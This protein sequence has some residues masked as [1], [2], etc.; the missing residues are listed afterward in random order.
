MI[1]DNTNSNN[2]SEL[3]ENAL[4]DGIALL[5]N[6]PLN[7][8]SFDVVA[9]IRNTLKIKK[10]GHAGTL[11]PLASGL[12]IICCGKYTKKIDEFQ[13]LFKEYTGEIKLGAVTKSYDSEFEEENICDVGHIDDS[14]VKQV[15]SQFVGRQ[16]QYPPMFSAK[17]VKGKKLYELAR[18]DIQIE[19]KPSEVEIFE[20]KVDYIS[21]V[22]NFYIK[23]SK[24]T[25]IR[26]FANDV[27]KQLGVG[28]YLKSLV[29]VGIGDYK[30][31]NA[32]ELDSFIVKV[33]NQE[34]NENIQKF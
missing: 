2:I 29:R 28:A 1:Y 5:V 14:L 22:I 32:L 9:K 34:Y 26:S 24:G 25:Y 23:C 30:L 12:L 10:V 3:L 8:T 16:L 4:S 31:D 20:V 27:G 19:V 15:A 18:K 21:P 11:D 7:W 13:G 33:K 6:K 17:K